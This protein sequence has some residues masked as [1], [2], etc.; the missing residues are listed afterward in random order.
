MTQKVPGSRVSPQLPQ[1]PGMLASGALLR[2][3]EISINRFFRQASPG[4][5]SEN[6]CSDLGLKS[7]SRPH[8]APLFKPRTALATAKPLPNPHSDWTSGIVCNG[9]GTP[10]TFTLGFL[11]CLGVEQ[12][13]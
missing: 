10:L 2:V 9:M 11:L 7:D 6:S 4:S 3:F 1:A 12:H 5:A 13:R 8:F